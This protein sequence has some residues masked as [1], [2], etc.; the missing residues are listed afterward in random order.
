M[1]AFSRGRRHL[2][3]AGVM[4]RVGSGRSGA[5]LAGGALRCGM[6]RSDRDVRIGKVRIRAIFALDSATIRNIIGF[7]GAV[8][9]GV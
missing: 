4:G 2:S 7:H 6:P 8:N 9:G 5:V 1:T 3:I